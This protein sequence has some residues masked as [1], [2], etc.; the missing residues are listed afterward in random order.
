VA[1]ALDQG[2]KAWAKSALADGKTVPVIPNLLSFTL[3]HNPGAS[4]GLG[5]SMTW[6]ITVLACAASIGLCLAA[7]KTVSMRWTICLALAFAGACGNLIDRVAYSNGFLNGKVVDFLNYGWS[8]GNVADIILMIAGI[9]IVMLILVGEPFSAKEYD[10]RMMERDSR[11]SDV[12]AAIG[13]E[14]PIRRNVDDS[15]IV[16]G[17]DAHGHGTSKRS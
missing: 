13:D 14:A 5:S 4:L 9:A 7:W 3:I 6:L 1:L 15:H 2:T 12:A 16:N 10:K 17:A 8:I 11:H